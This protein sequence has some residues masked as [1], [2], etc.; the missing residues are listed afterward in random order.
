MSKKVEFDINAVNR[1]RERVES[2]KREIKENLEPRTYTHDY[3]WGHLLNETVGRISWGMLQNFYYQQFTITM[4]NLIARCVA[5]IELWME[6][7]NV[8]YKKKPPDRRLT[9]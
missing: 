1:F 8:D 4:P 9:L 7:R 6:E 5:I 2:E 3:T